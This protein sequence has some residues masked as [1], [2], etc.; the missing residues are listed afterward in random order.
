MNRT[1][2]NAEA[3][4]ELN[5]FFEGSIQARLNTLH[6]AGKLPDLDT[7]PAW[8]A[9]MI[10]WRR[11]WLDHEG[12]PCDIAKTKRLLIE[13]CE[14]YE[15]SAADEDRTKDRAVCDFCGQPLITIQY[16]N[17]D[18]LH[19]HTTLECRSCDLHSIERN[20]TTNR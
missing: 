6:A 12:Q 18:P 2:R 19:G 10:E 15:R 5:Q 14:H 9:A 13:A 1:E 20:E 16:P 17:D 7:D 11:A 4:R 3:R 8:Q